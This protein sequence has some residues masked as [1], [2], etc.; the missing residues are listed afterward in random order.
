MDYKSLC[1]RQNY[2]DDIEAAINKQINNELSASYNY[3][4][5]VWLVS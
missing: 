3:L 1:V 4:A 2:S 5:M